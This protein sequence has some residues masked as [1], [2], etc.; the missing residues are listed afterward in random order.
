MKIG[1]KSEAVS[2]TSASRSIQPPRAAIRWATQTK[3]QA[4]SMASTSAMP[5]KPQPAT[6]T[7]SGWFSSASNRALSPQTASP[8]QSTRATRVGASRMPQTR[9]R[10]R[11]S[12]LRHKD[13]NTSAM[14]DALPLFLQ[15]FDRD[16]HRR[17]EFLRVEADAQFFEQPAALLDLRIGRPLLGELDHPPL[18]LRPERRVL[19]QRLGIAGGVGA[20]LVQPGNDALEVARVVLQALKG[21]VGNEAL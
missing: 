10:S 6:T 16:R 8:T 1:R 18:V 3:P 9:G 17:A 12:R 7:A 21:R 13:W 19:G 11:L 4:S 20:Q 15:A 14:H 2:Q 5:A